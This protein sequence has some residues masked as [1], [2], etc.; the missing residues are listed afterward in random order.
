[1]LTPENGRYLL[2]QALLAAPV[3]QTRW[4]WCVT[5]ALA[6]LRNKNGQRVPPNL[7][8]FRSDDLLA[9]VFPAQAGC[10]E[11]HHGDTEIPDHPLIHQTVEDCLHEA[12]DVDRWL[13]LLGDIQ[14]GRVELIARDTREPSPFSHEI[15]NANPYAFLDGAPLEERRARAV[16]LRR[17]LSF[18]SASDLGRLDPEA[19]ATV[20]AEAWPLVRDADELH[21]ALHGLCLLRADE[22]PEWTPQFNELLSDGRAIRVDTSHAA[23]APALKYWSVAERWPLIRSLY[24]E[25]SVEPQITL[26]ESV[27]QNW[28][29]AEALVTLL[30]GRMQVSGPTTADQLGEVLSLDASRVSAGLEAIEAEGAVLRGHF[31]PPP[32]APANGQLITDNGHSQS[33]GASGDCWLVSIAGRLMACVDKSR[34]PPAEPQ[35]RRCKYLGYRRIWR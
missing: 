20:R 23:A 16:T 7:Q 10:L 6:V 31:T 22:A 17:G 29:S 12:M 14:T 18:D 13:S 2:E 8:R 19:I 34:R 5:R 28:E 4:R 32:E 33:N 1:M 24:P 15:L 9:A 30:R 11:N 25:A 3:F 26:P 27:R 21:D 35:K